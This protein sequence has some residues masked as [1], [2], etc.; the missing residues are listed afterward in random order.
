MLI[1]TKLFNG[2]KAL[3][4][5]VLMEFSF[6]ACFSFHQKSFIPNSQRFRNKIQGFKTCPNFLVRDGMLWNEM[7]RKLRDLNWNGTWNGTSSILKL[8]E[9]ERNEFQYSDKVT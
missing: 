4:K 8:L 7:E 2:F 6:S 5:A 1:E 3:D 9:L